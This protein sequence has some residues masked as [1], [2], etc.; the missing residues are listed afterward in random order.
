VTDT[1]SM[2]KRYFTSQLERF[3]TRPS[4]H[5]ELI[6]D[7][8]YYLEMLE[9]AGTPEAFLTR[10]RKTGN[11][12]STPKAQACDRYR[13]RAAI[14][15]ALG[16]ARKAREDRDR[17]Q[18]VERAGT[19]VEL[20]SMLEEFETTTIEGYDEDR[21][22]NALSSVMSALFHLCTDGASSGDRERSLAKFRAYWSQMLD[23]DPDVCWERMVSYPAYRD[24]I[25]F[26]DDQLK[27]LEAVF[28]EVTDG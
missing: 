8:E 12:L 21:A 25:V 18:T 14:Y 24:R 9:E 26:T 20:S 6:R 19:H 15:D 11:M 3:R 22:M 7:C 23:A 27:V 16:Q 10:V 4:L 13:N 2:Q 17:V 5:R 1:F 28:K